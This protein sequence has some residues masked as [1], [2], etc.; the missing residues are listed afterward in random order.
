LET[1]GYLASGAKFCRILEQNILQLK[2]PGLSRENRDEWDPQLHPIPSSAMTDCTA[3]TLLFPVTRV[4]LIVWS[5][6][7][8]GWSCVQ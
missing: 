1:P 8:Q 3:A 4:S 6:L 2:K 5:A 7:G